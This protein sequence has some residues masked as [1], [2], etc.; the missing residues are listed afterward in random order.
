[1]PEVVRPELQLEPVRGH[2]PRRSHNPRIVYQ[3]IEP[4]VLPP[5][6]LREPAH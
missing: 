5:E 3:Q 4:L 1:M 6:P 2:S